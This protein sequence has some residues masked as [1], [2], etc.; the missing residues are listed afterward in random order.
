MNYLQSMWE[1]LPGMQFMDIL[2]IIIVAFLIYKLLPIFRSTGTARI[3]WVVVGVIIIS[4][5][6]ELLEL[7]TL[8]FILSQLLAVGLVAIVVLFQPELRRMLDHV[9]NIKLKHFFGIKK[10]EQEMIPVIVQTVKACEVMGREKIGALIVFSRDSRM[11]EYCKTGTMIDGQVSEQLIRNVFFPRASLH[12]GAMI[13]R[14]GRV[15]AAG[16]VLPLSESDRISADLGTRHRAAV[17][18]SEVTDAVTVIVS[19]ETGAISVAVG[20]VL[21]RHLAPQTLERLLR[22]ELCPE[23]DH[24]QEEN[25]V[26]K[27]RQKL[28]NK[29]KGGKDDEK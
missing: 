17:G 3:A 10:P 7:H 20:G 27:L 16:C 29:E 21:K 9:T 25:L 2:D 23:D 6:T 26:V 11:D 12:D 19:E 15:L 28:Q 1:Q 13:I 4:S 5:L 14:D 24:Q 8:H 22:N 18:I